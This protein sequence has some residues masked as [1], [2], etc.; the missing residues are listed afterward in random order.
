MNDE[1][2]IA[3]TPSQVSKAI[4]GLKKLAAVGLKLPIPFHGAECDPLPSLDMAYPGMANYYAPK[5]AKLK[6]K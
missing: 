1:M 6:K 5:L 4:E 2:V 3:L